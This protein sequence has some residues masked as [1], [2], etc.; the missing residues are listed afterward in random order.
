MFNLK[1]HRSASVASSCKRLEKWEKICEYEK[2]EN[3]TFVVFLYA[4][5]LLTAKSQSVLSLNGLIDWN[6]T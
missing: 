1:M 3:G 4:Q 2:E 5:I 6:V